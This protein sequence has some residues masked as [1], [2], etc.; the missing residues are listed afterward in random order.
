[1]SAMDFHVRDF[2]AARD[3]P[4]ALDF[5]LGS[6]RYEHAVEA[7]RRLDPPVADEY[8]AVLMHHVADS[9][10]RVFVAD[11]DGRAIGW[12]VMIF[13]EHPVFVEA[14][15]RAYGYIAELF[16]EEQARGLGAG[17]ALIAACEAEARRRG[18]SQIML[19]VLAANTRAA[20]IY[21]QAGYAP[22]SLELRKFL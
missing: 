11:V 3:Q 1:M 14:D 22:Y 13:E 15:Q 4:A 21:A 18:V 17:Q 16:V 8:Y 12:A 2:E 19:G 5:I 20:G 7:N 9:D 10:G 6:Q